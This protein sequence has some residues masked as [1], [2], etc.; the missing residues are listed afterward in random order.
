MIYKETN[1]A[2]MLVAKTSSKTLT[3]GAN[4]S[5]LKAGMNT[6]EPV[7][8]SPGG[9]VLD[10]ATAATLVDKFKIGVK[11]ADGKLN[12]SDVIDAKNVKSVTVQKYVA[13]TNQVDYIGYNGTSGSIEAI[14]SNKYF[15]RFLMRGTDSLDFSRMQL[16][17]ALYVSDTSATQAKIA[18]GI[19][20][21]GISNFSRE[22]SKLQHDID[23]I[24]FECINSAT[25]AEA[26]G[27]DDTLIGYKGSK[28]I[29]IAETGGVLPYLFAVGDYIRLGTAVTSPVY[30]ITATTVTVAD[31]GVLTLDIPL[32]ASVSYSGTGAAMYITAANAA[33][34]NFGVKMTGSEL[35]SA[36]FK[37]KYERSSWVTSIE[38]WGSTTITNSAV[39]A[40][41]SGV[42]KSVREL[43]SWMSLGYM[44]HYLNSVAVTYPTLEASTSGTYAMICIEYTDGMVTDLGGRADA[45]KQLYIACEKGSGTVYTDANTGLGT[46]IDAYVAKYSWPIVYSGSTTTSGTINA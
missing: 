43:E 40:M 25:G 8:F 33:A 16:K 9:V 41:G 10:A 42:G 6:G 4:I 45:F 19:V 28:Y 20:K 29:T 14:N 26:L 11:N 3:T 12:F 27:A 22:G 17:H 21:S 44:N 13:G 15:V 34:G 23:V 31:G 30:K 35:Y 24:K 46:T 1:K 32:Q 38:G 18:A 2:V 36:D 39:S 5:T 7:V 37:F